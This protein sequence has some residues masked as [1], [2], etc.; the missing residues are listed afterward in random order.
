MDKE[1]LF[2]RIEKEIDSVLTEEQSPKLAR[3]KICEI[4]SK[5]SGYDWVGFY[6]AD[7]EKKLLRLDQFVGEPTEHVEIPFGKGICGQSAESEST[8]LVPDVSK[9]SNYLAC[10]LKVKSEIVIPIFKSGIFVAQL[11]ID[12]HQ[13]S[14]FG[15]DDRK[16]LERICEKISILF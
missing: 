8:F 15:T 2:Q 10:S 14:N 6:V 13:K 5:L 4:L 7:K 12:S 1:R 3:K 11:D 16:F 9:E